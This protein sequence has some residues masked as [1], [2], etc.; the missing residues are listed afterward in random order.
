[1][2]MMKCSVINSYWFK[3]RAIDS[4]T[5]VYEMNPGMFLPMDLH[6]PSNLRFWVSWPSLFN[7]NL[8]LTRICV[9]GYLTFAHFWREDLKK[10][11]P[12]KKEDSIGYLVPENYRILRFWDC[13][14]V[15]YPCFACPLVM[16]SCASS[17]M[18][19]LYAFSGRQSCSASGKGNSLGFGPL[20]FHTIGWI[21]KFPI[22]S[23]YVPENV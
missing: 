22:P 4:E 18:P 14:I 5:C 13:S 16:C 17:A 19:V 2:D 11:Q 8:R 15:M 21:M 20:G 9:F 1:M 7:L 12:A 6:G 10:S 3:L 23:I